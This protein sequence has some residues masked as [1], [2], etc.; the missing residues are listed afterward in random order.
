MP[1]TGPT[2]QEAL[3]FKFKDEKRQLSPQGSRKKTEILK[4]TIL[5]KKSPDL[6][7]TFVLYVDMSLLLECCT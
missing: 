5:K 6:T 4:F 1:I 7:D 3:F 2:G